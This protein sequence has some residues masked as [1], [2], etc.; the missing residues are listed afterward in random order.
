MNQVGF[1]YLKGLHDINLDL[2]MYVYTFWNTK[3]KPTWYIFDFLECKYS[4][5]SFAGNQQPYQCQIEKV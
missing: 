1:S 3:V 4:L 2:V 5:S